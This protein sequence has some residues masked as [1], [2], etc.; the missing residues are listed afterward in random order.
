MRW[1]R[2]ERGE[3]ILETA[4]QRLAVEVVAVRLEQVDDEAGGRADRL[5]G[6]R[7]RGLGPQQRRVGALIGERRR[8]DG[9]EPRG[10]AVVGDHPQL[11]CA[12]L[13]HSWSLLVGL[14]DRSRETCSPIP[15][16]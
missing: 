9:L 8:K 4:E 16:V 14:I 3:R 5:A 11:V 12:E 6:V 10:E 7:E 2:L 1:T 15:W 13:G